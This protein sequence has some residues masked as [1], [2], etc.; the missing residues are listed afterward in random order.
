MAEMSQSSDSTQATASKADS[1]PI[2]EVG[3]HIVPTVGDDG[4]AAVVD[5]VRAAIE[6]AST[7]LI[8]DEFPQKVTLAYQIERAAEGRR[9]KYTEAY[10]GYIKFALSG[11]EG[12]GERINA[13]ENALRADRAVLRYLLVETVREDAS[14]QRRAVFASDRL[15]G[16]TIKKPVSAPE[17]AGEV[18][19]A[20]LD[21]SLD[22]LTGET[23]AVE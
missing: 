19:E 18:S 21:K 3:Y 8:K 17:V 6:K 9:E 4:V 2:F 5:R 1:K 14:P 23:P 10:F 13:L 7:E 22:A 11:E 15:E 16:E 12:D 20:E